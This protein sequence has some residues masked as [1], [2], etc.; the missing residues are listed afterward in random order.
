M[1]KSITIIMVIA[2]LA[3]SKKSGSGYSNNPPDNGG[4]NN[5]DCGSYLGYSLAKDN[6][7][8][9]YTGGN[10]SKVYVNDTLCTCH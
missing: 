5:T 10:Y 1:K 6:G 9:Y 2:L 4:N 3:C 7:G 8:C